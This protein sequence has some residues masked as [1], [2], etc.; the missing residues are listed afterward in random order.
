VDAA[1]P[2]LLK[3]DELGRIE[4]V[5]REACGSSAGIS[6]PRAGGFPDRL[7]TRTPRTIVPPAGARGSAPPAQAQAHL[8]PR[9]AQRAAAAYPSSPAPH[10]RLWRAI[11]KRLYKLIAR[12]VFGYWDNEGQGRMRD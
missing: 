9:D 6:R 2:F 3:A 11:G 10:S 4:I 5:E 8:L 12:R 1:E 7:D